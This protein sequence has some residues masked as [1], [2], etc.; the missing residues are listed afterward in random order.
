MM[1]WIGFS[2]FVC[3][4]FFTSIL[5]TVTKTQASLWQYSAIN[6]SLLQMMLLFRSIVS[7]HPDLGLNFDLS[8][9]LNLP[10]TGSIIVL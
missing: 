6:S 2:G 3:K 1:D 4:R 5:A 10:L 8:V 7:V 9:A